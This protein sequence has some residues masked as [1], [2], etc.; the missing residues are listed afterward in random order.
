MRHGSFPVTRFDNFD[1]R[2]TGRTARWIMGPLLNRVPI[3]DDPS[4]DVE[5]RV[6][7]KVRPC[8]RRATRPR[9]TRDAP[10]GILRASVDM[11]RSRQTADPGTIFGIPRKDD[12]V[13]A[14]QVLEAWY[15]GVICIAV[16]DRVMSPTDGSDLSML[17]SSPVISVT[18]TASAAITRGH[19]AVLGS[20]ELIV[21]P[22][23]SPH[24]NFAAPKYIGAQ[25]HSS[26][27]IEDLVNAYYGLSTWEPYPGRP[28]QLRSLIFSK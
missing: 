25:W 27:M 2:Q 13:V 28:E 11:R 5:C 24:R 6:P 8:H 22:R 10:I 14:G 4:D 20:G 12:N 7:A 16:F 21:D 9:L 1:K 19:W 15:P 3:V 17:P 18:S 26:V 23:F